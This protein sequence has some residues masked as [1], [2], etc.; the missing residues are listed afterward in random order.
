MSC[1]IPPTTQLELLKK[2]R[3]I[4]EKC[5]SYSTE[6]TFHHLVPKELK[7]TLNIKNINNPTNLQVLCPKCHAKLHKDRGLFTLEELYFL[8]RLARASNSPTKLSALPKLAMLRDRTKDFAEKERVL[9][10]A[11]G[12]KE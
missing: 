9:K 3:Y 5:N 11:R 10:C 12:E 6:L 4:C 1:D 7:A 2:A 8:I